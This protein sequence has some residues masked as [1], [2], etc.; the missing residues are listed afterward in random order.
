MAV[1]I[2]HKG[3]VLGQTVLYTNGSGVQMSAVVTSISVVGTIGC[4]T[5]PDQQA[6]GNAASVPYDGRGVLWPSW[7]WSDD[8]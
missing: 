8:L 5:F 1:E 6:P 7:M 3:P 4:T 2:R